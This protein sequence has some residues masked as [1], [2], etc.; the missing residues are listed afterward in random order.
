MILEV[1]STIGSSVPSSGSMEGILGYLN[2][3][4]SLDW[5]NYRVLDLLQ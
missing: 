5:S 1:I 3:A 2:Q 4:L